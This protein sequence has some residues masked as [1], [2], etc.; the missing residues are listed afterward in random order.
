[1]LTEL[2]YSLYGS[3]IM[4]CDGSV[5]PLKNHFHLTT[6]SFSHLSFT[7]SFN[8][9]TWSFLKKRLAVNKYIPVNLPLI[10]I[11][12]CKL[13]LGTQKHISFTFSFN[14]ATWSF[15]KKRLAVNKYI[16]VNL[17]LITIIRC[18]LKLGTQKHIFPHSESFLSLFSGVSCLIFSHYVAKELVTVPLILVAA[19][20]IL[21][22][23][24]S[25]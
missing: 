19:Y 14:I 23:Q 16:P 1:M 15:L 9:A 3:S 4:T 21:N 17:P 8:I 5:S 24:G 20:N 11:I 22:C 6:F 18:K 25:S 7:F 12:R 2:S 13:K 10:T